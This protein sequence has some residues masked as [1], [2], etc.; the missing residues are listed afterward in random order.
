MKFIKYLSLIAIVTIVSCNRKPTENN[1]VYVNTD[2]ITGKLIA[3]TIIYDVVINNLDSTDEWTDEC[4]Q[5]LKKDELFGEVFNNIYNG[6]MTAYNF[7]TD[8]AL[9]IEEVKEIESDPVFSK[10][11]IGKIQFREVWYFDGQHQI[12]NKKVLCMIFGLEI[13]NNL[14][15]LKGYRPLFKIYTN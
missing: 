9:S 3:D 2:T 4:L 8:E 11:A 13:Y 10:D 7:F 15:E 14:G 12:M 5:Y 1:A 6:N